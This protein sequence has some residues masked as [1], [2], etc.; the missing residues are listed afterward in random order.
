[1]P[2]PATAQ[3]LNAAPGEAAERPALS[4][5]ITNHRRADLV[6]RCL[7]SLRPALEALRQ[8][9]E[10]VVVDDG[11]GDGGAA[12]LAGDYPWAVF[13]LLP[14]NRGYAGALTA[15]I[16][17][18]RGEWILTLNNDTTLAPRA[19]AELLRTAAGS[20]RIGSVAALMLFTERRGG[21][22]NSAGL[23]LDRLCFPHDR[24]LGHPP[25]AAGSRPVEVFGASGGAALHRRSMLES[26]G[27][28]DDSFEAYLEDADL[29]WRAR[30]AGWSCVLAPAA[31]V[32]HEHSSTTRHG[33]AY[34]YWLVGRNRVRLLAK[35]ATSAHLLR[36]GALIAAYDLAYVVYAGV[37]DRTIAPLRGRLRGLREWRAYRSRVATRRPVDLTRI[38]GLRGALKRRRTWVG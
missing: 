14:R 19:L 16:E 31:V 24:L 20:P 7:D 32:R 2:E 17:L 28:I 22:I 6:R 11:S 35:N 21:A 37:A 27:G 5:V 4:V 36:Y 23:D 3:I 38:E 10:T 13:L 33:S 25:E 30:M 1:M 26:V 15:G 8:P 9:A 18:T 29:S 12:A 34:K